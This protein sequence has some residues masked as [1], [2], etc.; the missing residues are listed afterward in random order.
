MQVLLWYFKYV[1]AKNKF[2][3][4]NT[5]KFLFYRNFTIQEILGFVKKINICINFIFFNV[6]VNLCKK[7]WILK[8]VLKEWGR[9]PS[10]FE[11]FLYIFFLFKVKFFV[12]Y[13]HYY[14]VIVHDANKINN[15][16]VFDLK[17]SNL[18]WNEK[19]IFFLC[20][21]IKFE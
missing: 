15:V 9:R 6:N 20:T 13:N 3:K 8:I 10:D 18:M 1:L 2:K 19:K 5:S 21:S 12:N 4:R 17:I 11:S 7:F 14:C 16:K